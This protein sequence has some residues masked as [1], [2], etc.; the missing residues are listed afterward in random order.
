MMWVGGTAYEGTWSEMRAHY[1][2]RRVGRATRWE[3]TNTS[4]PSL[5]QGLRTNGVSTKSHI[6][7][8][9]MDFLQ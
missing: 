9:L 1:Q 4:R 3:G 5:L 8:Y 2:G 6:L 7:H